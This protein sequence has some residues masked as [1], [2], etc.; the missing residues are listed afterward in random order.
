MHSARLDEIARR[1]ALLAAHIDAY[2][3]SV[4]VAGQ[5]LEKPARIVDRGLAIVAYVQARPWLVAAGTAAVVALRPRRLGR[6]VGRGWILW[7]AI[8][9]LG[10]A[11]TRFRS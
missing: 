3:T 6:W 11:A 1:K 5:S 9:V 2:R 10:A 8:G 4:A 7:R